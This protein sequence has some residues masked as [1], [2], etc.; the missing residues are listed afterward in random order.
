[1]LGRSKRHLLGEYVRAADEPH[2]PPPSQ[3]VCVLASPPLPDDDTASQ[4]TNCVPV[5]RILLHSP[6][7]T[8][9]RD[10]INRITGL[11][12]STSPNACTRD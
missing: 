5:S 12:T 6:H 3:A 1:M 9:P 7:S 11:T 10:F 4:H 8:L 2:P